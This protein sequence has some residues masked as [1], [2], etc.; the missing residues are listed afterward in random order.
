MILV[1]E[2]LDGKQLEGVK[3]DV[4]SEEQRKEICFEIVQDKDFTLDL[5]LPEWGKNFET[6]FNGELLVNLSRDGVV[7]FDKTWK[8]GDILKLIIKMW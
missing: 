5:K 6:H 7:R 4:N 3:I 2:L 8:R 1:E